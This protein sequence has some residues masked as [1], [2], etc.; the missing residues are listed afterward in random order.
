MDKGL[1]QLKAQLKKSVGSGFLILSACALASIALAFCKNAGIALPEKAL[2]LAL[3]CTILAITFS[4]MG[5]LLNQCKASITHLDSF[6]KVLMPVFAAASAVSGSPISAVASAGAALLFSN[7]LLDTVLKIF[8]PLIYGYIIAVAAGTMCE[9]E[10][11]LRGAG[12]FKSMANSL[13][14][15][16]LMVF[17][18]YITLSGI[19]TSGAD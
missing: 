17:V 14:K 2:E 5:S 18:A 12:A 9:S 7:I 10:L 4:P 15:G 8:V 1:E 6:S 16:L 3:I 13:C 19:T 11:L